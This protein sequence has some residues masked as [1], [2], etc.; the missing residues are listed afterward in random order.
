VAATGGHPYRQV[1]ARPYLP[2]SATQ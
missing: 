1:R 2:P